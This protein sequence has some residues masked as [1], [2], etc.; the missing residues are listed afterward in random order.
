MSRELHDI[1]N[2]LKRLEIQAELL[3]KKDF[4]SFSKDEIL[5][6]AEADIKKVAELLKALSND[7]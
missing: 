2:T 7:Q 4:R 1:R 3:A 6:D 5:K